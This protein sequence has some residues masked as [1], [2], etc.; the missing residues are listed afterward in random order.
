MVHVHTPGRRKKFLGPN[1]QGKVAS[2][3]P[4]RVHPPPE[5]EQSMHSVG[6][7]GRWERLFR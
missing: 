3:S 6:R 1:L 5:A 4:G 2:A 7:S